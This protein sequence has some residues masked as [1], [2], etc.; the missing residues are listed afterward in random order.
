MGRQQSK[1]RSLPSTSGQAPL[2]VAHPSSAACGAPELSR[3]YRLHAAMIG[4][5]D[6]DSC[7]RRANLIKAHD[8]SKP[9]SRGL[10][11]APQGFN[12][13][14]GNL[15][16]RRLFQCHSPSPAARPPP[17][18]L[19][20]VPAGFR[21]GAR[22]SA[23]TTPPPRSTPLSTMASH[24]GRQHCASPMMLEKSFGL[25]CGASGLAWA[26]DADVQQPIAWTQQQ[27]A[28]AG[29]IRSVRLILH[30][31]SRAA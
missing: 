3:V 1:D 26:P 11:L 8:A 2:F 4:S 5:N 22:S 25:S 16:C 18:M 17:E 31:S 10:S 28:C 20:H 27:P 6:P 24:R 15:S 13:R 7:I 12:R 23:T 19:V 14:D 21:A 29:D 30:Y 9:R